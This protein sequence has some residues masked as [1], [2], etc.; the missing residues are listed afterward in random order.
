[1]A[2]VH[3]KTLAN[4]R[5]NELC[6]L[7]N[8]YATIFDFMYY[9]NTLLAL[10][11]C[12]IMLTTLDAQ[13]YYNDV[14][15]TQQTNQQYKLLSANQLKKVTAISYEGNNQLSTDFTLEQ[16]IDISRQMMVTRSKTISNGESFLKSYYN[17]NRINKTV[18]SNTNAINT[19]LYE[20]EN[21]GRIKSINSSN[22]DFDG[23]LISTENHLWKYDE[24]GQP[25]SMLKIKN[26]VDTTFIGF[27]YDEMGNVA[28]EIW[29]KNN[30]VLETYYYY[31]N[32]K[33]KISDIVRFNKKANRMLPDYILEYDEKGKLVQMTQSQPGSAN[34]LIW[35]Y[36]YNTQGLKNKELVYN[37][38]KEFL[39]KIEY[40]Y[41]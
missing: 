4:L 16:N 32:D 40:Q 23:K 5:G 29:R 39:G 35:R 2:N 7:L 28:E 17:G 9:K 11:G 12:L 20:Y 21:G 36:Q 10:I 38:A 15:G 37:K 6:F 31:Y 18:D 22:K 13:Y 34:Y 30:R 3:T 33:Q 8:T 14:I 25:L 1:M 41:Q 27:K 24:K 19:V 26:G